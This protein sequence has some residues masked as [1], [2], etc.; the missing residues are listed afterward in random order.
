MKKETTETT[1]IFKIII[2]FRYKPVVPLVYYT[3]VDV[4][5][6]KRNIYSLTIL[7]KVYLKKS[8]L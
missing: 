6:D 8:A 1:S 4:T 5:E 2:F 7:A 3:Y